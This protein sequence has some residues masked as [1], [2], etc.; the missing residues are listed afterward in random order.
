M[1]WTLVRIRK[2]D[3]GWQVPNIMRD[4]NLRYFEDALTAFQFAL[5]KADT[6]NNL[7]SSVEKGLRKIPI[8]DSQFYTSATPTRVYIGEKAQVRMKIMNASNRKDPQGRRYEFIFPVHNVF[9]LSAQVG[10]NK[11]Q[12]AFGQ[13]IG[14]GEVV[15]VMTSEPV[16]HDTAPES[17][18]WTN[19]GVTAMKREFGYPVN[20]FFPPEGRGDYDF[21][22][23]TPTETTP[24]SPTNA[25]S[26]FTQGMFEVASSEPLR[27]TPMSPADFDR[28]TRQQGRFAGLDEVI[29]P[30]PLDAA[31]TAEYY[32]IRDV[33]EPPPI[34]AYENLRRQIRA[35]DWGRDFRPVLRGSLVQYEPPPTQTEVQV[36]HNG[37]LI[38]TESLIELNVSITPHTEPDRL[39]YVGVTSPEYWAEYNRQWEVR[40]PNG[41]EPTSEV[42][43]DPYG[44]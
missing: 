1:K 9:V 12:R 5:W 15:D 30:T 16:F 18:R 31:R 17:V 34:D 6:Y 44:T 4:G 39:E 3:A 10:S 27:W 20:T 38:I 36:D 43:D 21:L 24:S 14:N 19:V 33:A 13:V 22:S 2:T 29:S 25:P 41:N 26:E 35:A 37:N 11:Q 7:P 23:A 32:Q 40:N 8:L 28:Y 42:D